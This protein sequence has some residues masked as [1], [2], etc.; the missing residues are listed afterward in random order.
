MLTLITLRPCK[1]CFTQAA[2]GAPLPVTAT[3][4]ATGG[5][6]LCAGAVVINKRAAWHSVGG[7]SWG[8]KV[9][10]LNGGRTGEKKYKEQKNSAK[11][12]M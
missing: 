3:P 7:F 2:E 12:G 10:Q 6:L 11:R 1:T 8:T 5:K 4:P 9:I